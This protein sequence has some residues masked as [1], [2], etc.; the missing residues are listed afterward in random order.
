MNT[1]I[2]KVLD[3]ESEGCIVCGD[4][5]E[6]MADMPDGC[7]D[8][9]VTDIP[10]NC[11]QKY[12]RLRNLD[13]GDWDKG[14]NH[15][16]A[17]K[18]FIRLSRGTCIV[19]CG[20]T[21]ISG[22]LLRMKREDLLT[23]QI[24]WV[25]ANPTVING[26]K[27]YLPGIESCAYGKKRTTTFN[28]HCHSGV[29]KMPPD[30]IRFHPNQKPLALLCEQIQHVSNQGDVILDPFVGSGT[31]CVAAKKLGRRWIGIELDENY[32]RIARNRLR[33]TERPLFE[34][35]AK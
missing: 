20:N 34:M 32:C 11:S 35:G 17:I 21:Q 6:V 31:T 24:T 5:L 4:C 28:G 33:D 27:L 12:Q 29:W 13:Y 14:F 26:D 18:N 7:V 10:Y 23:R 3:G 8:A 9:I 1:E 16:P 25:K 30:S 15:R 22:I 2:Q 19:W